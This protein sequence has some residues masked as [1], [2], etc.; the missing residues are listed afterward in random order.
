VVEDSR[1][2]AGHGLC[3]GFALPLFV[4][5]TCVAVLEFVSSVPC[6]AATDTLAILAAAVAK[7]GLTAPLTPAL[8]SVAHGVGDSGAL[9]HHLAA[10]FALPLAQLW[11]PNRQSWLTT[12]GC[13]HAVADPAHAALR[14]V[15]AER[16]LP[17]GASI[18]GLAAACAAPLWVARRGE[19]RP[20][21]DPFA[22][23]HALMG[24]SSGG[25]LALPLCGA[26]VLEFQLP[27]GCDQLSLVAHILEFAL[28][29]A[30]HLICIDGSDIASLRS[31]AA[32]P[33]PP[34]ALLLAGAQAAAPALAQ[35][36]FHPFLLRS[37]LAPP[38]GVAAV[39]SQ[40]V[41]V[42]AVLDAEPPSESDEFGRKGASDISATQLRALFHL[43]LRTAAARLGVC[44]S[45]VKT[46]CRTHGIP[47]W[48]YRSIAKLSANA[49]RLQ[50]AVASI[51]AVHPSATGLM[52]GYVTIAT[53][54]SHP[55]Q[56][57]GRGEARKPPV[58]GVGTKRKGGKRRWEEVAVAPL[59]PL[60]VPAMD[61]NAA[62]R[63]LS[64]LK[65][66]GTAVDAPSFM[67]NPQLLLSPTVGGDASM[68][69]V[70]PGRKGDGQALTPVP[71]W[72]FSP[73]SN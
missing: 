60:T 71:P 46:A 54:H 45:T 72:L 55:T 31:L 21:A 40:V 66:K 11:T 37:A 22:P 18:A 25:T 26:C 20:S 38:P 35:S 56:R 30:P 69:G 17:Q 2:V 28:S 58:R 47:R 42:S 29:K 41:S 4:G 14:A 70:T 12:R 19:L 52:D 3:A 6:F 33:V 64:S 39:F 48:P 15:C 67:D 10:A 9:L 24:D 8:A 61:E 34:A 1:L 44:P 57:S 16:A 53:H 23:M 32:R 13:A 5:D 59:S 36:F 62:V 51:E 49:S 7:L 68:W 65:G 43:P 73:P 27:S 63:L 50:Q